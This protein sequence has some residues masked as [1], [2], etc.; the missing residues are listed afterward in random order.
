M[1][2]LSVSLLTAGLLVL[3]G[4]ESNEHLGGPGAT[5]QHQKTVELGVPDNTF[6]LD[7]PT[8]S[9]H[10][11]QGE[12]KTVTIGIK[13]GKN[14]DQD[15]SLALSDLPQ[16]VSITPLAPIIKAG[17][18]EVKLDINAGKDAALGDHDVAVKGTPA[19]EGQA[20]LDHFKITVEKP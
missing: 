4:C 1:K 9:T 14:F 8:F 19:R 17:E 2:T 16:G 13:R 10:L 18:K 3:V 11:K 7:L 5:Q 6:K 12:R 15:V 20:Y